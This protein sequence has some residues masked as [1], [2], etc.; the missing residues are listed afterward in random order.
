MFM[1]YAYYYKEIFNLGI[2]EIFILLLRYFD[3][4]HMTI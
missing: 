1:E 4:M 3:L 2:Y